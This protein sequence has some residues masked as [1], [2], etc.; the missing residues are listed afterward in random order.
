M[1]A[2][3][4]ILA[5]DSISLSDRYVRYI[6]THDTDYLNSIEYYIVG[7]PNPEE[8]YNL[9]ATINRYKDINILH[10]LLDYVYTD[11]IDLFSQVYEIAM[12]HNNTSLLTQMNKYVL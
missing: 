11:N 10:S 1:D 9:F 2:V 5:L 3:E 8:L 12:L 7:T 4:R 6:N